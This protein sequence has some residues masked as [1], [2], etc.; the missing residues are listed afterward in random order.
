M[1]NNRKIKTQRVF[2]SENQKDGFFL[3][4]VNDEANQNKENKE[5]N[6]E[7][8]H[9]KPMFAN[10]TKKRSKKKTKKSHTNLG[11]TA[12]LPSVTRTG[13][14][15]S[16]DFLNRPTRVSRNTGGFTQRTQQS[17][18]SNYG[19]QTSRNSSSKYSKTSN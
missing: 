16:L 2:S 3:T 15:T 12:K 5:N 1:N 4:S 10:V 13:A 17:T 19:F 18:R 7:F 8:T 9:P 14:K 11:R 6:K